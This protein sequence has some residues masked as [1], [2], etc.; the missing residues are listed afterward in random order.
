MY[1]REKIFANHIS[2]KGLTFRQYKELLQF[3]N[4]NPREKQGQRTWIDISKEKMCNGQKK[5]KIT[6]ENTQH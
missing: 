1:K 6:H 2:E 5:K 4:D 3:S